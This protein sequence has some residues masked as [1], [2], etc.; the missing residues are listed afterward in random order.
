MSESALETPKAKK[1]A[2]TTPQPTVAKLANT[3][4]KLTQIQKGQ[5]NKQQK[6]V[7]KTP[8]PHNSGK[9]KSQ[10]SHGKVQL[11]KKNLAEEDDDDDDED[12]ID[13]DSENDEDDEEEDEDEDEEEDE[14]EDEDEEESEETVQAP[15]NKSKTLESSNKKSKTAQEKKKKTKSNVREY[16]SLYSK[17]IYVGL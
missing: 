5:I 12:E 8:G 11:K 4:K 9:V 2:I 7:I 6:A 15:N 13:D 16:S 14:E 10:R 1:V 3:P 17:L